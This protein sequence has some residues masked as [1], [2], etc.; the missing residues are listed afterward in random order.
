LDSAVET[1][2]VVDADESTE[3]DETTT[4]DETGDTDG[5][6][7]DGEEEVT[8]LGYECAAQSVVGEEAIDGPCVETSTVDVEGETVRRALI[9]A[10]CTDSDITALPEKQHLML[11][12]ETVTQ[13]S[14]W[15][16]LGGSGGVP[17]N[18]DNVGNAAA[19]SGYRYISL[20]YPNEP[21]IGSRCNCPDGPR[22]ARCEGLIRYEVLYGDDLTPWFDMEADESIVNRLTALLTY[23]HDRRPDDGWDAYLED[24]EIRWDRISLSG[25]SQGGGMAGLIA[26]D[27][28]VVRVMYLSKGAGSTLNALVDPSST[29][30]CGPDD[31]CER[32]ACCSLEDPT[33][34]SAPSDGLC[35]WQVPVPWASHGRDV[36]G[37]GLGDGEASTRA[38]PGERQF[39]LVHRD[40]GAWSYSPTVFEW[41]GLGSP[42]SY[43][44]ADTVEPPYEGVH[45]FSTGL[46]PRGECSEH[47]SMGADT[48]QP[49]REDGLPAMWDA[50]LHAMT[51]ELE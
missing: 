3:G 50:W 26:R 12:P 43:V 4:S 37:D 16:H 51:V 25:F 28:E 49:R 14:L 15:L 35:V 42:D 44:D 38:T 6:V 48:C 31:A 11:V 40:E 7:A 47:Q 34:R 18:T 1:D 22:P 8:E 19:M 2:P 46:P 32:G 9:R 24:G 45:L 13:Q 10:S 41:W 23:L 21:S 33:C 36:D 27:H 20:A 39:A 17:T 29:P 30:S 5:E